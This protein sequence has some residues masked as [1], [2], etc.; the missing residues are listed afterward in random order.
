[1]S[2]PTGN[3]F[4]AAA[5]FPSDECTLAGGADPPIRRELTQF[6]E[7]VKISSPPRF[8]RWRRSPGDPQKG[9]SMSVERKVRRPRRWLAAAVAVV[10]GAVTDNR[11][12][13]NPCA[14][15]LLI[16]GVTLVNSRIVR[17]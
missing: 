17:C 13:E 9:S 5:H 7:T 16:R 12:T 6:R 10:A 4:T 8:E 11:I 15:N 1:M 14:E 3:L 2:A